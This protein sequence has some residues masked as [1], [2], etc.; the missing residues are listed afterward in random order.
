MLL[1][2]LG[3][4]APR[5]RRVQLVPLDRL[6]LRVR[7]VQLVPLDR[8]GPRGRPDPLGLQVL[9]ARR[10]LLGLPGL[11]VEALL[12]TRLQPAK[13]VPKLRLSTMVTKTR[14]Y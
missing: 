11:Q 13:L 1:V 2:P 7:R 8:L 4:L 5:V 9:R 12:S 14:G 10:V 6:D 3:R